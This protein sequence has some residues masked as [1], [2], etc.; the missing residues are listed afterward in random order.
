M[1]SWL[2]SQKKADLLDLAEEAGLNLDKSLKKDD[3]A[4]TLEA[5]LK[6]NA[7]SLS[8]NSSLNEYYRRSSPVK[9]ESTSGP[10]DTIEKT[11]TKPRQ[12]RQTKA[13]TDAN[14][15]AAPL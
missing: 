11:I 15:Y 14:E 5:H 7:S 1:T 2:K 8:A 3:I 6:A 10:L 9:R 4:S 13:P 12:R